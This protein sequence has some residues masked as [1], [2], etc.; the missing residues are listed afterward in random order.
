MNPN[1]A[2][3]DGTTRPGG[4]LT[5]VGAPPGGAEP[6][7]PQTGRFL[8]ASRY[9]HPGDVIRLIVSAVVLTGTLAAAAVAHRRLLSPAASAVT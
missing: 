2:D 4:N 8:P 6:V 1:Q 5:A 9:R 3:Q 7:T